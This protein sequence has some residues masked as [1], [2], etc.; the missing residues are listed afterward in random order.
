MTP[1]PAATDP[2]PVYAGA[3]AWV[4]DLLR[5]AAPESMA[6]PTP[7]DDLDV[8][9]LGGHLLGTAHRAIAIAEGRDVLAVPAF[10]L[11]FDPDA[12]ADA[13]ASAIAL[14]SDDAL[15]DAP[16][17]VPWGTVPGR[18]ALWGYVNETLVHGWDLAVATGQ[19][20]EAPAGLAEATLPVAQMFIG[21][22]IRDVAPFDEVVEPRPEAGAT[23]RLANWTGRA[24]TPWLTART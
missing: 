21:A 11:P 5:G 14:W 16:A 8:A 20:P 19:S 6:D 1:S 15:L 13:T 12:Y 24:S 17:T 9:A 3:T 4:N 7:C 10:G 22:D 18:G 23:E 2:R